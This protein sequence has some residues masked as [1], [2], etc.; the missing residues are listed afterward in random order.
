[1]HENRNS[2]AK[3]LY[4]FRYALYFSSIFSQF[5]LKKARFSEKILNTIY[6]VWFSIQIVPKYFSF[7]EEFGDISSYT[8]IALQAEGPK[9]FP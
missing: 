3:T 9:S 8:H 1:M 6:V 4:L 7:C 2:S 5:I